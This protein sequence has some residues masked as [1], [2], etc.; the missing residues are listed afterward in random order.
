MYPKWTLG[1]WKHGLKPAV[2]AGLILTHSH[3]SNLVT[4]VREVSAI[5]C[6]KPQDVAF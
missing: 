3:I 1:K 4:Q 6:T 2:P 5:L